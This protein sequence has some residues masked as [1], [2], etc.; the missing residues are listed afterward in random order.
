MDQAEVANRSLAVLSPF[1]AICTAGLAAGAVSPAISELVA[2][3]PP[4]LDLDAMTELPGK[5]RAAKRKRAFV[6]QVDEQTELTD[7]E[8]RAQL[9][10]TADILTARPRLPPSY[11]TVMAIDEALM[12]PAVAPPDTHPSVPEEVLRM[13][14]RA[15][16]MVPVIDE[17]GH[18]AAEVEM[19]LGGEGGWSDQQA[20]D[21]ACHQ[22][23]ANRGMFS[24]RYS[25]IF[26]LLVSQGLRGRFRGRRGSCRRDGVHRHR[27]RESADR[28]TKHERAREAGC[29]G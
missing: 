26:P 24:L 14:R 29:S 13:Y 4:L 23:C 17:A 28:A 15:C 19:E 25:S 7:A 8:L 22:Q 6:P 27:L 21:T 10:D 9:R 1:C 20:R 2:A 3:A 18:T 16:E 12:R 11:R 5:K